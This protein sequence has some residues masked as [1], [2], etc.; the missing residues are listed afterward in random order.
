[1]PEVVLAFDT[2]TDVTAVALLR[3]GSAGQ[4][5]VLAEEAAASAERHA[6]LLL[7]RV[8]T[9][10]SRAGLTLAQVDLIAVGVGPG[11][12]TGV[13]VG[14]AT[15]KGFAVAT[16][17]RVR[18]VIS[19]EV[20]ARAA[21]DRAQLPAGT[22]CAPLLDAHKGEVFAGLYELGPA[23]ELRASM[24]P[25]HALPLMAAERV[26]EAIAGRP[27]VVLGQGYRRYLAELEPV[28][29]TRALDA[30]YDVPSAIALAEQAVR[31]CAREGPSDASK[32]VPEYLRGS[33]AQLPKTPLRV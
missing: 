8:N 19:L 31:L 14:L 23:G 25:F 13:R 17:V 5:S 32:L 9:C 27:C 4:L 29:A 20:L 30:A 15:A 2:S 10:L 7:P 3:A 33:D 26:R 18:G 11:S 22:L 1:M 16:N 21:V 24:P 28:L 6:Q 12:F